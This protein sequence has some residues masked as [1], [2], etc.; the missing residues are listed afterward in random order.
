[1]NNMRF[2]RCRDLAGCLWT[3]PAGS[4]LHLAL[5]GDVEQGNPQPFLP[6]EVLRH[7]ERGLVPLEL[8]GLVEAFLADPDVQTAHALWRIGMYVR[9]R[10]RVRHRISGTPLAPL[11]EGRTPVSP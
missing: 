5:L 10:D 7:P 9:L 3:V 11:F 1:M 8:D 2:V 4:K 6:I